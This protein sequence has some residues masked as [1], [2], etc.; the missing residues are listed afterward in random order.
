MKR[1]IFFQA[2]LRPAILVITFLALSP[3]VL[4]ACDFCG[5]FM[6]VTPFDNQN[7]FALAHRYR[8]FNGYQAM[9]Q[10]SQLFPDGSY[11]H[12]APPS[13]LHGGV[14]H[15]APEMSKSD[16]E[17][18]KVF[19]LRSKYFIHPR[20]EINAL[21]PFVNNKQN[22]FGE[23]TNV[24]GLGDISFFAG[25]HVIQKLENVKTR[26]RVIIGAGIKL[27]TGKNDLAYDD[28]DRIS[29]M[30]QA[31]TGSTDGFM[32]VTYTA[33]K[34]G[35]RWGATVLGKYNGTNKYEEQLCPSMVNSGFVAYQFRSCSWVIL[36][37]LQVYEEYTNGLREGAK[38]IEG[39]GMNMILAGPGVDLYWKQI[40]INLGAQ[41]PVYQKTGE[42]NMKTPGR[43]VIGLSYSFNAT[44][45]LLN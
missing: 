25:W 21:I 44:K 35:W 12:A 26:Q 43:L 37:Q 33:A 30:L 11:R 7:S 36:P 32:Y 28:G 24:S 27:P 29:P 17:S 31:G 13:V 22:V 45:Y 18:F 15:S 4:H 19:E 3:I 2:L 41:L 34:N 5:A 6:G 1:K 9:N 23:K 20:V 42:M 39:T 40:G 16:F 14:S 38:L 10:N 8:V